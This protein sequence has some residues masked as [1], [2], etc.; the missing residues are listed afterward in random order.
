MNGQNAGLIL[1][2]SDGQEFFSFDSKNI[3]FVPLSDIPSSMQ[4]AVIAAEDKN[5]YTNPGFSISG[6]LRALTVDIESGTFKE[7]GSTITQQLVK[8]ALLS[9]Q[10]SF[11]R[12][13]QEIVFSYLITKKYT[14]QDILEMYLNSAYFGEGAFGVENAA[15]RYFGVHAQDLTLAQ[16]A[17][18]ISLLPAPSA[19][20]PLSND[21]SIAKKNQEE[22]LSE[23]QQDGSITAAQANQ[24][25]AEALTYNP[26]QPAN[27]VLAPH[28]AFMVRDML[29]QKYG[30]ENVI[31][32]GLK[33]K[34]TLNRS[35]QEY[36]EAVVKNQVA[37]LAGDG[38]TN[39][40]VVVMDPKTGQI[41]AYVGSHDWNDPTNGKVDMALSPRQP[42]SS[43][44]PI[45]YSAAFSEHLITPATILQDVPTTFGGNYSPH[46]Y[47]YKYRGPVTVRR[48]LANSLNIPAV[49]VMEQVGVPQGVAQ[50]QTLGITTLKDPSNYGLSFVLGAANVPLLELTNAYATFADQGTYHKP[51]AILEVR[52]KYNNIIESYQED[53]QQLIDPGTAFLISSILSDNKARAEEFGNAL[54]IS[55]PAAVKTGT[56][57]NFRDALTL[58]YTP[59]LTVGVWVGNNDNAPMDNIAGSLGAAPIWRS[60]MEHYLAGTSIE[61]FTQPSDVVQ[62]TVCPYAF[63][64]SPSA[65]LS[66]S[67]QEYFLAGTEPTYSTCNALP[68]PSPSPTNPFYE[69][70]FPTPT[71]FPT[72]TIPDTPTPFPTT[73]IQIPQDQIPQIQVP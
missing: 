33:V 72:P 36:A 5:F 53:S 11:L 3:S 46:D 60:L 22:V 58:G 70:Q 34:T 47:D 48:A 73:E 14:K 41:K 40:A 51:T 24:A 57:E 67:Y 4:Q 19:R 8:N 17:L 61:H 16:S 18:L 35:W 1:L 9:P 28:F 44:K 15:E 20:S 52:D 66:A 71:P 65:S 30:E 38:V 21:P 6:M 56:T 63:T 32:S 12:K 43:F 68:Q 59:S 39:G 50:A 64:G 2:D 45:I 54:T 27:N 26:Q 7:G 55:R 13:Y 23:M 10:K 29:F 25:K 62:A 37:R 69:N 42:G 49:E 31:R